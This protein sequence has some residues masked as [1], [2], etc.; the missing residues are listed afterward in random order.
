MDLWFIL[1]FTAIDYIWFMLTDKQLL[2][3]IKHTVAELAPKAEVFLFGSRAT[4]KAVADSDWDV[5]ILME[6]DVITLEDE[7]RV[8]HALYDLEIAHSIVI[9]PMVYSSNEWQNKYSVTPFYESVM[10]HAIIL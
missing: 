9:S 4:G 8:L 2:T 1:S 5:L 7:Q 6:Q 10:Q 3:E